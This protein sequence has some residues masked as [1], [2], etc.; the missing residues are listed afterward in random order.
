[1][2]KFLFFGAM[3]AV[4]F[5]SCNQEQLDQQKK[6]IDSLN[7][8]ITLKDS[9]MTLIATTL[10]G[11]Q[12]NLNYIKEK[13]GIISMSTEGSTQQLTDDI[14]AIYAKLVDNKNKVK[15]LQAKLNRSM[16]KNKEYQQIIE[17]LNQQIEEQNQHIQSLQQ[18]LQEKDVEIAFLNDAVIRSAAANDSLVN[19]NTATTKELEQTVE[20][21]NTCYYI[22]A[23]RG[24]L[25]ELGLLETSLFSKKIMPGDVNNAD[26][27]RADKTVIETIQLQ[28]RRFKVLTSHP[29]NTYRIDDEA[30]TLTIT[31]K[32]GFW[33]ASNYLIVQARSID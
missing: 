18:K 28:G 32:E 19:V 12:N 2:K 21:K 5:A 24:H 9:T 15:E 8:V 14:N 11:V 26:F 27:T 17:V 30:K 1:M 3:V 31:D 25:K 7:S 29:E 10:A 13:E 22:V 16:G 6:S 33:R 4:A 23:E 20:E